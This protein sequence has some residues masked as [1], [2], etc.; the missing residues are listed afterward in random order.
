MK[1]NIDKEEFIKVCN[2]ATSAA[3]AARLLNLHF[4]TFKRYAVMFGCYK[5]NQS[6]KGV[7]LGN[8][9]TR[10][11]TKD[12]LAGKY[13]NYQ[14]YKLKI[15]LINEGIKRDACDR[16]GWCEKPEG[17]KYSTCELHH[18]DGNNHNHLLD[19]LVMLCPNCH[20]LTPNFR[21]KNKHK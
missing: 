11:E 2:T 19:N 7:K 8:H 5:T 13:P 3:D 10:I 15:R 21:S 9:K 16:C 18:K 17:A 12:I 6:H 4:N 14:T 20:S 1:A